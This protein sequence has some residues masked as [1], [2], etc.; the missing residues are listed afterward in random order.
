MKIIYYI[1]A[2]YGSGGMERII[3]FKAN[4][5]AEHWEKVKFTFSLPN[6]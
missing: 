6:K 2:L 1:P 5:L 3:T 4:Y